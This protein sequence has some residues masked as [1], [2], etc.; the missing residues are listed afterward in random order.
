MSD[1]NKNDDE[2]TT[3]RVNKAVE[4]KMMNWDRRKTDSLF[5]FIKPIAT[6]LIIGAIGGMLL[7]WKSDAIREKEL[8]AI[9]GRVQILEE[10]IKEVDALE[11]SVESA[12]AR[13]EEMDYW[14]K[15]TDQR[16]GDLSAIIIKRDKEK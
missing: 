7:L 6:F 3:G 11:R 1:S 4:A 16:L 2:P 14:R 8:A 12:Q 15:A 10:K 13:R 5:E 9:I